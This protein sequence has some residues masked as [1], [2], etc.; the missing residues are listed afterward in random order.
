MTRDEKIAAFVNSDIGR[1]HGVKAE[2]FAPPA[3]SQADRTEAQALFTAIMT[4]TLLED[5]E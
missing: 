4:D 2:D 3:V 1:Q 5:E